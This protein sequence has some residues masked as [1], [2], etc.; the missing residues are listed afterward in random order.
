MEHPSLCPESPF[1][2]LSST[3]PDSSA[4]VTSRG[5]AFYQLYHSFPTVSHP[6]VVTALCDPTEIS[7]PIHITRWTW[8]EKK[9]AGLAL[10][11]W[12]FPSR[13]RAEQPSQCFMMALPTRCLT[14]L[15]NYFIPLRLSPLTRR[16]LSSPQPQLVTLLRK[17]KVFRELLPAS[18]SS[19]SY[20]LAPVLQARL[21]SRCR[22][23][24]AC[25]LGQC[26]CRHVC[27]RPHLLAHHRILP[28]RSFPRT[29]KHTHSS[30]YTKTEQTNLFFYSTSPL[31]SHLSPSFMPKIP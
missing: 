4:P 3:V 19:P 26:H 8:L 20:P 30:H 25:A 13:G 2:L 5:P 17:R 24:F 18:D 11:S 27:S 28:P 9:N 16:F 6:Y 29:C 1:Q 22:D 31:S 14:A 23:G 7:R 12:S 10:R 21:L 15:D